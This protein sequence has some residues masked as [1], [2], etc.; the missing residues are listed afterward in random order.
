MWDN[1]M[2][3]LNLSCEVSPNIYFELYFMVL[4]QA[5]WE[6]GKNMYYL[7]LFRHKLALMYFIIESK[8]LED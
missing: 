6:D 8:P 7:M 2:L 4:P 1:R 3:E 5:R